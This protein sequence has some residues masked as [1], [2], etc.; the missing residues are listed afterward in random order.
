[1]IVGLTRGTERTHLARAALE[2]MAYSTRDVA[3]AMM[4]ASGVS[5]TE[6]KADGGAAAND[7]L[8]QFQAN[9]LGV[10]V[11]R[12]DVVETTAAGAAGL[13]GLA[14]GVWSDSRQF[15]E[16]RSYGWFEPK[17]P[18]AGGY[19]GWKRAVDTALHWARAAG[20]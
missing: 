2:A 1:M 12:P 7:W 16:S 15:L 5:L 18:Y 17:T 8:M 13:A 6:L 19:E 11:A 4:D 14:T 10:R 9:T 3:E 20:D